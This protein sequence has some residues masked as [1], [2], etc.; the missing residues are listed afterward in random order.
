MDTSN[1]SIVTAAVTEPEAANYVSHAR[2]IDFM[3]RVVEWPG[4]DRPRLRQRALAGS[5]R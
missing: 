3:A 1:T 4:P 2:P 5:A